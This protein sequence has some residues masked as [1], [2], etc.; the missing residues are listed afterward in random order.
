[1]ARSR[2]PEKRNA[3]LRA[4]VYEIA[5]GGLGAATAKIAAQAGIASGTLFT[6]FATKEE[7]LNELYR[8][9]KLEVYARINAD[10]PHQASLER[11]ARHL[12]SSY[13]AW[14]IESPER[15]KVSLQLHISDVVTE[16]TRKKTA[17]DG[18]LVAATLA[19]LAGRR[20]LEG[21]PAGFAAALMSSMQDAVMDFIARHPKRREELMKRA[22]D[23]YWRAVH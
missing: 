17:A 18:A 15:R 6:Y 23:V 1:M 13:M 11:R 8:E 16:E 4:A 3:I 9:L 14:A 19:E 21:L 20:A 7:L 22:F 5:R 10:F 12:W 2:S